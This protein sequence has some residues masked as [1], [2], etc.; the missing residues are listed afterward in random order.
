MKNSSRPPTPAPR[1]DLSP[2]LRARFLRDGRDPARGLDCAGV[3][4]FVLGQLGLP[5]PL[6]LRAPLRA[7]GLPAGT[8]GWRFVSGDAAA[9]VPAGRVIVGDKGFD[10]GQ[11]VWVSL[12]DGTVAT[13]SVRR[14]VEILPLTELGADMRAVYA[15]TDAGD[16]FHVEHS[17]PAATPTP[18]PDQRGA[19]S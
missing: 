8:D 2:I 18:A 10:G 6:A 9:A 3:V 7:C 16:S 12:G 14:G 13:A 5:A 11:H 17:A 19:A 1:I 15:Y 4:L